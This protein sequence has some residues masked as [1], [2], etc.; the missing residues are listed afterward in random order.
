MPQQTRETKSPQDR[1]TKTM[2]RRGPA[3]DVQPNEN[4]PDPRTKGGRP[5]EPVEDRPLVSSVTP[6][7]YPEDQR[8]SS[9][10]D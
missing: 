10:P 5:Q 2:P 3:G 4:D 9:K 6:E 8:A 7:D 1:Q